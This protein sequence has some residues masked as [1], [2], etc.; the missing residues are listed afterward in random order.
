MTAVTH[1][2][3][4][5]HDARSNARQDSSEGVACLP[6]TVVG[7]C[8]PVC[9]NPGLPTHS[10]FGSAC[11]RLHAMRFL[12]PYYAVNERFEQFGGVIQDPEHN[13]VNG[14]ALFQ[15]VV[16]CVATSVWLR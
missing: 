6:D 16:K 2:Q 7:T 10:G 11:R 1:W 9:S 13:T 8:R 15:Y 14:I 5:P 12:E 4:C 3:L